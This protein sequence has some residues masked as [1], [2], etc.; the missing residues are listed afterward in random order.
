MQ[1]REIG[2]RLSDCVCGCV[3]VWVTACVGVCVRACVRRC[4]RVYTGQFSALETGNK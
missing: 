1:C 2:N 3:R 4:V